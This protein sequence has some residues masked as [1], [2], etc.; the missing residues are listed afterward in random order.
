MAAVFLLADDEQRKLIRRERVSCFSRT[1]PLDFLN[2][3]EVIERYRLPR[4][5]LFRLIDLVREDAEPDTH[6][7]HALSACTQVN[8]FTEDRVRLK[9]C[10]F[11]VICHYI[12]H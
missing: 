8:K 4:E 5:F 12:F 6:R 1:N 2:D 11:R 3:T 7:S 10:I 9:L